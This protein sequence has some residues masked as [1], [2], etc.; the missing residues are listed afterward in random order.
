MRR[1]ILL[2]FALTVISL[3]SLLGGCSSDNKE[4]QPAS[5]STT[6]GLVSTDGNIQAEI[7]AITVNNPAV[8]TFR[9]LNENGQP[10][11]PATLTGS[12]GSIRFMIARL[13][14]DGNYENFIKDPLDATRPGAETPLPGQLQTV[15]TGTYTYT[16]ATDITNAVQTLGGITLNP[17]DTRTHTVA[18]EISRNIISLAGTNFQQVR[19]VYL[20]FRPDR[21]PVTSTRE[22]VATSSCNECHGN[23]GQREHPHE[24]KLREVALCVLCHN[25]PDPANP[26]YPGLVINGVSFDLK[27]LVHKI[28][29]GKKLPGNVALKALLPVPGL[30]FAINEHDFFNVGHPF[31]STDSST[32]LSLTGAP[33][34][35]SGTPVECAKCHPNSDNTP[36]TNLSG[37]PTTDING[38]PFG[39]DGNRWKYALNPAT[40]QIDKTQSSATRENCTTC[41]DTRVF[42]GAATVAV[43]DATL[44]AGIFT[45]QL[46]NVPSLGHS[47]GPQADGSCTGCHTP[48]LPGDNSYQFSVVGNHTIFEKSSLFVN[49]A[50]GRD[51]LNFEILAVDP[52]TAKVGQSPT[53]TFKITDKDGNPVS[54]VGNSFTLKLGYFRQ[55]DYVN[56]GLGNFGQP[57]SQ[58]LT[59]ATANADG[60]FTITF[61]TPIPNGAAGIGVI[62]LEGT[63]NYTIP[64]T[65]TKLT[66]T[67][68]AS[69]DGIQYY[70]DLA[71]GAQVTDPAKQRRISVD[72]DK[73]NRCH[74]GSL[75]LHGGNRKNSVQECV[76]C[77]NP[78]ATDKGRRPV[79]PAVAVDGLTEQSIQFKVMI[80]RIHTGEELDLAKLPLT[81]GG[82]GYIIYGFGATPIDFGEVKYPKDRRDCLACHVDT[83][84]FGLPLPVGALATTTDTG[85]NQNNAALDDN[86]RGLLAVKG[87]CVSCH[88]TAIAANHADSRTVGT[89]AT[90]TETCIACHK[91]G[92]LLGPDFAHVPVR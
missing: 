87:T 25:P 71:T 41:H 4:G 10:L 13:R 60:S 17:A 11:N 37:L 23:I 7:T 68:R 55:A 45:P 79:A 2:S 9:L 24:G 33:I 52:A 1:Y 29:M 82:R 78:N 59:T 46:T 56:D 66:R 49:P 12:V 50:T 39:R 20:N 32:A 38:K 18:I 3:V 88:D 53:V 47:A 43:A 85:A 21:Q 58:A 19:N 40:G 6:A 22:I 31:I 34:G 15:G 74:G 8:V 77:H 5:L 67:V 86:V 14:N 70:F 76:I 54:P 62:G 81:T 30:G 63:K 65:V 51:D 35:N 90:A 89:G 75:S 57:L 72:I 80:H 91:T 84:A 44:A 92:L 27:A 42:D 83:A 48:Q 69:G 28:H 36:A 73:C 16:F 64:A 26:A 61:A